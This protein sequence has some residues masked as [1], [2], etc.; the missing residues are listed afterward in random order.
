MTLIEVLASM[1]IFSV[2]TIGIVPL[3]ITSMAGAAK[4]RSMNV[5]KNIALE[6]MER[7]RSLPYFVSFGAESSRVDVLDLYFPDLGAGYASGRYTTTCT[8]AS[9]SKAC[10]LE[11][12]EGYTLTYET[13]FVNGGAANASGEEQ[14][15][16]VTPDAGYAWNVQGSDMPPTRLLRVSVVAS[17]MLGDDP[18]SMRLTSLVGE[19][20]L[21]ALRVDGRA[22][23]DYTVQVQASYSTANGPSELLATAGSGEAKISTRQLAEA[24]INVQA[25]R[26]R[27]TR[28]GTATT[29]SQILASGLGASAVYHAPPGVTNQTGS[30]GETTII[31]PDLG[32][33]VAFLGASNLSNMTASTVNE[34]PY[35]EGTFT[36]TSGAGS[37]EFYV[38]NQAD[39]SSDSAL[40][41][42]STKKLLRA[43]SPGNTNPLRGTVRGLTGPLSGTR[44]VQTRAQTWFA[45]FRMFPVTYISG[46]ELKRSIVRVDN[47]T[48]SADC[49]ADPSGGS[50]TAA[51]AATFVYYTHSS[52]F[53]TISLSSSDTED[54]LANLML[55]ANNPVVFR[56]PTSVGDSDLL[57]VYLFP[58]THT[59]LG[60]PHTHRSYLDSAS[61]LSGGGNASVEDGGRSVSASIN[62]AIRLVTAPTNSN[63]SQTGFTISM[64]KVTCTAVDQR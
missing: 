8:P 10:A 38:G 22:T 30:A 27:L 19:R 57:D 16:T 56:D 48:A 31:H 6:A 4:S 58:V 12:P 29:S 49:S 45:D 9:T 63:I 51:Y 1:L 23:I 40:K 41:L 21:T 61:S 25:S 37:N 47:F 55:P 42:D 17:W 20:T 54:K 26:V 36:T 18:E 35:A 60:V 5:G 44:A 43:V 34:L 39:F 14:Y 33:D 2:M 46:S 52:G 11:L 13:Q 53:Q 62:G 32:E 7:V 64:G 59:I 24:D 28:P 3:L 50:A 15:F